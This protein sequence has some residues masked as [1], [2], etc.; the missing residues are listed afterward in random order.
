MAGGR[1][2]DDGSS[3]ATDKLQDPVNVVVL[4]WKDEQSK[5]I[6][7]ACFGDELAKCSAAAGTVS[8]HDRNPSVRSA[9]RLGFSIT[10]IWFREDMDRLAG[11]KS[12]G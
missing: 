8:G 11:R 4:P 5:C 2:S 12:P 7:G 6:I 3:K 10:S 9:A 1:S